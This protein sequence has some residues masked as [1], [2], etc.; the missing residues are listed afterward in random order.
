MYAWGEFKSFH[1]AKI[2]LQQADL[3][4]WKNINADEKIALLVS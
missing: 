2:I 1:E 3:V 4:K